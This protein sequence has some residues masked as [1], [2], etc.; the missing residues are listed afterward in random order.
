VNDYQG[1]YIEGLP[2]PPILLSSLVVL[3]IWIPIAVLWLVSLL[4]GNFKDEEEMQTEIARRLSEL[5]RLKRA[6]IRRSSVK[7]LQSNLTSIPMSSK[8]VDAASLV[9]NLIGPDGKIQI[10]AF[11][12]D[13]MLQ[14]QQ[15]FS[16]AKF[17]NIRIMA[18]VEMEDDA[19]LPEPENNKKP[20]EFAE[21]IKL[22]LM[23]F[24]IMKTHTLLGAF[25][26]F[27]ENS[28]RP[29]RLALLFQRTYV[30]LLTCGY[31]ATLVNPSK[32]CRD[33][34][35]WLSTVQSA[36]QPLCYIVLV[37]NSLRSS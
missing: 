14:L 26:K 11:S 8:Q 12:K 33:C 1:V 25:F 7:P 34:L 20:D 2:E 21:Q 29:L 9:K 32:Y 24:D 15:Q 23:I 27:K 30:I 36:K 16:Q 13:E 5:N 3:Y 37:N 10:E 22:L 35:I 4:W 31:L 28:P 18:P 19:Y 17:S 6:S